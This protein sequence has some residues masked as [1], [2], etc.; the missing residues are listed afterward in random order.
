MSD[1]RDRFE[2][3]LSETR[4]V[5]FELAKITA[6]IHFIYVLFTLIRGCFKFV[7][8]IRVK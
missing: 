7:V 5:L 2:S 6:L 4:V 8:G 3:G 1:D